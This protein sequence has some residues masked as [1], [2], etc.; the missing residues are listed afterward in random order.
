M[1]GAQSHAAPDSVAPLPCHTDPDQWFDPRH[2]TASLRACLSCPHRPWCAARAL[3]QRPSC[4]MWA[5]V[6]ITGRFDA[7]ALQLHAIATST[8]PTDIAADP[9]PPDSSDPEKAS[10]PSRPTGVISRPARGIS[11]KAIVLARASG[12]C[13]VMAPG[14][15]L[16]VSLMESRL[17]NGFVDDAATVFAVCEPC[18]EAVQTLDP[19]IASRMGFRVDN[20]MSARVTPFVWRQAHRLLFDAAGGLHPMRDR[21]ASHRLA[22]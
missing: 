20:P 18:A 19:R 22:T 14:C 21:N 8:A 4:G 7:V 12:H 15:R 5:G 10:A 1:S 2:R 13:E 3:R 17:P 6:W 9:T 11:A 16:S